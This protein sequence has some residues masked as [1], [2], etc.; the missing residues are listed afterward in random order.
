MASRVP[1]NPLRDFF[2][3]AG[4][5]RVTHSLCIVVFPLGCGHPPSVEM[6]G[7]EPLTSCLQSRRSTS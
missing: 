6:R 4:L 1:V 7:I 5:Y 3:L 2:L